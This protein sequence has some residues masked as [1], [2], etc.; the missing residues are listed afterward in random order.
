MQPSCWAQ[1]SWRWKGAGRHRSNNDVFAAIIDSYRFLFTERCPCL[2]QINRSCKSLTYR[3]CGIFCLML[4]ELG[5]GGTSGTVITH[6]LISIYFGV[7]TTLLYCGYCK[8]YT[9]HFTL[10]IPDSILK[11]VWKRTMELMRISTVPCHAGGTNP[12]LCR[13]A[14]SKL[15]SFQAST[16][17]A[18]FFPIFLRDS[19][20]HHLRWYWC[21]CF[22]RWSMNVEFFVG[23]IRLWK[24]LECISFCVQ[25]MHS[26]LQEF[27]Q[28]QAGFNMFRTVT[29]LCAFCAVGV[30]R[31]RQMPF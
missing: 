14:A 6:Q 9:A 7:T 10:Y 19:L 17:P 29:F 22:V 12:L 20:R 8:L 13:S 3:H 26:H 16:Q 4:L 5:S 18:V 30:P 31:H 24:S 23:S 21:C 2:W 27:Q 25:V 11:V 15:Y 28:L 1:L